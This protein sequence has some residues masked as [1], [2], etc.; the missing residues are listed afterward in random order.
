MLVTIQDRTEY[1]VK[2]RA[3]NTGCHFSVKGNMRKG[4]EAAILLPSDEIKQATIFHS[5]GYSREQVLKHCEHW[6]YNAISTHK[7]LRSFNKENVA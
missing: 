3:R 7:V 1:N 2:A 6:Q 4:Y 5:L